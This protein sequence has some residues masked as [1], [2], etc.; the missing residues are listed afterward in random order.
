[1]DKKIGDYLNKKN[2]ARFTEIDFHDFIYMVETG[3]S[4]E[5]IALELGVSKKYIDNLKNEFD[6]DY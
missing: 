3:L 4:N 5:E 2:S 6:K 1:M